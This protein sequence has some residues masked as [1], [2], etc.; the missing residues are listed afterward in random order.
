MSNTI[1][2]VTGPMKSRKTLEVIVGALEAQTC[3]RN[4]MAFHPKGSAR[5]GEGMISS[6]LKV[7]T[8]SDVNNESDS[9]ISFPSIAIDKNL[10][11]FMN[12][13]PRDINLVVFD[14]A[15]F[16]GMEIVSIAR[17]LRKQGIDV[18][19]SGLDMDCFQQP[20]GPMPYLMAIADEV[21]KHKTFCEDCREDNAAVS[22]R[23]VSSDEQ[24]LVGDEEYITL[25]YDCWYARKEEADKLLESEILERGYF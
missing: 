17:Q 13:L 24:E 23:L 3:C 7:R 18:L 11:N 12:D 6:R 4:V 20:F 19:I 22:Y 1:K 8:N 25:C 14:D 9:K 2:V 10:T 16:F 5:W 15:Q 21:I